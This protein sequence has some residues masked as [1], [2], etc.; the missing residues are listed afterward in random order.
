[1]KKY[2]INLSIDQDVYVKSMD[3]IEKR[4]LSKLVNEFLRNFHNIKDNDFNEEYENLLEEREEHSQELEKINT[5]I[6]LLEAKNKENKT[7]RKRQ[8]KQ[9]FESIKRSGVLEDV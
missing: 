2:R 9:I 7:K 8:D 6:T 5:K 1:M 4:E 3:L